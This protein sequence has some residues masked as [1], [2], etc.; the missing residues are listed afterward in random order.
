MSNYSTLSLQQEGQT[1]IITINRPEVLNALA[2]QVIEDLDAVITEFLQNP[3]IKGGII[4]GAGTKAFVAGADI[5]QIRSIPAE[6]TEAFA[7]R[8]QMVFSRIENSPKPIIAAVNG[9]A[10]GGGCELAMSCHLRIASENAKFGQP[11]VNLGLVAGYGGTQRLPRLVGLG[12]ATEMLLTAKMLT[13]NE[14]LQI[15][16]ANDVVPSDQLIP[17]SL[18]MLQTI[19]EKSPLAVALTLKAIYAGVYGPETG[20]KAEAKAFGDA[21]RSKDGREGTSAFVEKRKPNFTGE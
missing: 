18:A 1:L 9:F 12:R 6:Q 20:M 14:A 16:L 5:S 8:G 21:A 13:A 7:Q 4:T 11:E 2:P 3:E 19:Y 17:R 15:G 10:L